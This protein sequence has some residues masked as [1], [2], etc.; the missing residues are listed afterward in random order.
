M[1]RPTFAGQGAVG[2]DTPFVLGRGAS[3]YGVFVQYERDPVVLYQYGDEWGVAVKNRTSTYFGA[4]VDFN[5]RFSMR[6]AIPLALTTGAD[7]Q[8]AAFAEE[9]LGIGDFMLGARA[10]LADTGPLTLG[11][12]AD[13]YLPIGTNSAYL[14]DPSVRGQFGLNAGS[15]VGPVRL[16]AELSYV[17]R[18]D[19]LETEQDFTLESTLGLNVG[20]QYD[21]WQDHVGLQLSYLSQGGVSFLGEGGGENASEMIAGLYAFNRKGNRIDLGVGK[22]IAPGVGTTAARVVLAY[23]II[24]PPIIREPEPEPVVVEIP[25]PPPPE[26]EIVFIEEEPEPEWEPEQKV[27]IVGDQV[28]IREPVQF[29]LATANIL[30]ESLPILQA[31]ADILN[32]HAEIEHVVI[33]GH[34]SIEGSYEYNYEL[35][36]ERARSIWKELMG[37]GVH[38]SRI[39]YRGMGEVVPVSQGESEEELAKNRRV[40]FDIVDRVEEGEEYPI[41][42]DSYV[43]P[44]SGTEIE[45][46]QPIRPEPEATEEPEEEL[47]LEDQLDQLLDPDAF[48]EDELDEPL[49]APAETPTQESP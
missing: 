11:A 24:T 7:Q 29:E 37:Y 6:A 30:E 45:T 31:V 1:L 15:Q 21:I 4:S 38:P 47:S 18:P 46:I 48:D 40:E 20:A 39:S 2:V 35:S 49:E 10:V 26:P 9:G 5:E 27:K 14:G 33:E 42:P 3:R 13:L 25:P 8:V 22:G 43:L 34:A 17:A 16:G 36:N 32:E 44:W 41:Y 23:T 28:V 12:R 19:E